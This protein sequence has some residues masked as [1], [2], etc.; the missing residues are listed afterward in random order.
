MHLT[1]AARAERRG[2]L[3][4]PL[5]PGQMRRQRADVALSLAPL[6][7]RRV[8]LR[9][10]V[11]GRRRH[12]GGSVQI[13]RELLG[14]DDRRPL[15]SHAEDQALQ[16]RDLG[17]QVVVLAVEGEHHLDEGCGVPGEI[18]RA[19][20]HVGE[21]HENARNRQQ[22]KATQATLVGRFVTFGTTR[23]HSER[24]SINIAS[25]APVTRIVPSRTGGQAKPPSSS[26]FVASTSP[27]PSKTK[28]FN[29]SDQQATF[30]I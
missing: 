16:R 12:V 6:R 3:D 30:C 21:L 4:H 9:F 11:V 27:E 29:R 2:R 23:D 15:R 10:V 1:G 22:N 18:F 26:H 19:N 20:R 25:C 5:D 17:A 7:L 8:R 28:S 14:A 24:P 13:Q